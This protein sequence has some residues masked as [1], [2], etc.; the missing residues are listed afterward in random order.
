MKR[1]NVIRPELTP[2]QARIFRC[3]S[4]NTAGTNTFPVH[5]RTVAVL[6]LWVVWRG[7]FMPRRLA[8]AEDTVIVEGATTLTP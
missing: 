4:F 1:F 6:G 3:L 7:E 5:R 2:Q 8:A